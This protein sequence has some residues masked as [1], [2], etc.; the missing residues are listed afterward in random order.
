MTI[1]YFITIAVLVFSL[2][3]LSN[4]VNKRNKTSFNDAEWYF[5]EGDYTNARKLYTELVNNQKNNSNYNYKL[6]ITILYDINNPNDELVETYLAVAVKNT[7]IKYKSNYKETSAPIDAFVFYGDILRFDFKFD[8][9]IKSYEQYLLVLNGNNAEFSNYVNREIINCNTAKKLI[10]TEKTIKEVE[11]GPKI[12]NSEKSKSFPLVSVDNTVSVFA[13]GSSNLS[14][15][16]INHELIDRDYKTDDFYFSKKVNGKWSEPLNIT[17]DLK[18]KHQAFPVSI[19]SN[20]KTLFIV[21]DDNDDGNI[22][23]SYYI[24]EKWTAIK[25]LNKNINSKH[26]ETHASISADG[27][28]LFFTSDKKGG[29]G[30]FDIYYSKQD[31]N[32][33]WGKAVNL[34]SAIN[35]KYDEDLPFI[36]ADNT[37]LYFCSQGHENIGGYDIF[38]S[39]I[40]VGV[41]SQPE[42]IGFVLNSPRNNLF[43]VASEGSN[44]T[45]SHLHKNESVIINNKHELITVTGT[46]SVK[47][48]NNKHISNFKLMLDTSLI[49]DVEIINNNFTFTAPK[50]LIA[51]VIVADGYEDKMLLIDLV[52]YENETKQL[53]AEM[54]PLGSNDSTATI[55]NNQADYILFD[56]N[57]SSIKPEYILYLDSVANNINDVNVNIYA[58]S[59]IKGN[60]DYNMKLSEA[61]ALSVKTYLLNKGI[62]SNNINI[63][64]CGELSKY[65]TDSLNRRVDIM[66]RD[67]NN[68]ANSILFGFNEYTLNDS[69]KILIDSMIRGISTN[70]NI[71]VLA[72]T[73]STGSDEYNLLLS[74]KRASAIKKYLVSKSISKDKIKIQ[75]KGILKF[76]TEEYLKRKGE[77]ILN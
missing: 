50:K 13:Y 16:N 8:D 9:A 27:K 36:G 26:W 59:D 24:N 19:S 4:E 12:I 66:Y 55:S 60:S 53:Y 29:Y 65:T 51:C 45:F 17:K 43:Y 71:L 57:S 44:F 22:Y 21:Q 41:P 73:D 46:V 74:E 10:N 75:G 39:E 35:T 1:K 2:N 64:S 52:E 69:A 11:I 49:S 68:N 18:I 58:Y 15:G 33:E 56:Y 62:L 61:R 42:N 67:I 34:G 72:Y 5:M 38:K 47:S 70:S 30:G 28:T 31:E 20:G 7:S 48:E 63:V 37:R 3:L 14:F 54:L 40:E 23:V 77:I 25:K 32:F 76:N 6:A